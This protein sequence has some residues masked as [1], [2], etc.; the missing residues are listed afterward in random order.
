MSAPTPK[1]MEKATN[2]TRMTD[3]AFGK[4]ARFS[5]RMPGASTNDKMTASASG[6][7]TT[8][9]KYKVTTMMKPTMAISAAVGGAPVAGMMP[10]AAAVRIHA[11]IV[12]YIHPEARLM[13]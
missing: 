13:Q 5:R 6:T 10:S 8:W 11:I 7:N 2:T 1:M 9:P 12:C 3:G 4:P